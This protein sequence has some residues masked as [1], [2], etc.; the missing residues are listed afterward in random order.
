MANNYGQTLNGLAH[1]VGAPLSATGGEQRVDYF[2]PRRLEGNGL[3]RIEREQPRTWAITLSPIM[4]NS[5]AWGIPG[6]DTNWRDIAALIQWGNGGALSRALVDWPPHGGTFHLHAAAVYVDAWAMDP[7]PALPTEP[8]TAALQLGAFAAPAGAARSPANMAP[9]RTVYVTQAAGPQGTLNAATSSIET[10]LPSFARR[11]RFQW[12]NNISQSGV[13]AVQFLW[14]QFGTTQQV[15]VLLNSG[16]RSVVDE[17]VGIDVPSF[18][19]SVVVLNGGAAVPIITFA[20]LA[21]DL[22]LG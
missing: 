21:F 1:P 3:I 16:S 22:D 12:N 2:N 4:S 19:Q 20:R 5:V 7:N 9:R 13:W 15:D 10:F 18:A 17:T 6:S 8:T 14:R 11:F